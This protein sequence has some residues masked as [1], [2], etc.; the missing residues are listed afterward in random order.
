MVE[1]DHSGYGV[2][3]N[4]QLADIEFNLVTLLSLNIAA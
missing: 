2:G 1:A 3:D 4:L